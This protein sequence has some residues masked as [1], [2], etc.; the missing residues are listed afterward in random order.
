MMSLSAGATF[1]VSQ[2]DPLEV[3]KVLEDKRNELLGRRELRFLI[4]Q[5]AATPPKAEIE[6]MVAGVEKVEQNRV[7]VDHI[8]QKYGKTVSE[9]HVKI[10]DKPPAKKEK[11]EKK[12]K[13]AK[14]AKAPEKK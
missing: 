4:K 3:L 5:D 1:H 7:V 8:Y 10:Y 11:K 13:E 6:K 9:V 2:D 12:A 14:E